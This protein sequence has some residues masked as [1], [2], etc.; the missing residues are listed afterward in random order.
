MT[1]H[2]LPCD[3]CH[4]V[5]EPSA[6]IRRKDGGYEVRHFET[7]LERGAFSYAPAWFPSSELLTALG[8][9]ELQAGLL[10]AYDPDP[11]PKWLEQTV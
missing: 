6:T 8:Y 4:R 1:L 9:A 10:A 7:F 2:A 11:R 5:A 3:W